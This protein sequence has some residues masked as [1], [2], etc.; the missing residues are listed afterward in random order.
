MENTSMKD[1]VNGNV[2]LYDNAKL[3]EIIQN[4]DMYN[5]GLVQKCK[6]ELEIRKMSKSLEEKVVEFDDAKIGEILDNPSVYSQAL[7]SSCEREKARRKAELIQQEKQ[8]AEEIKLFREQQDKARKEDMGIWWRKWGLITLGGIAL[9][10]CI[11]YLTDNYFTKQERLKQEEKERLEKLEAE[12]IEAEKQEKIRLEEVKKKAEAEAKRKAEAKRREEARMAAE[13]ERQK[14]ME[15]PFEIGGYHTPTGGVI[16][17]LDETKKHGIVMTMEYR[18][19]NAVDWLDKKGNGWRMPTKE[20]VAFIWAN[21]DLINETIIH[22]S[23][24]S[25]RYTTTHGYSNQYVHFYTDKGLAYDY[26]GF[27]GAPGYTRLVKDF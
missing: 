26:N 3:E 19:G 5:A 10:C 4:E 25:N 17:Y 13:K 21:R 24:S 7:I 20:E 18:N 16:I 1:S 6:E 23:G 12:R 9:L 14:L 22:K 2:R 11:M 15:G 8:A 27:L